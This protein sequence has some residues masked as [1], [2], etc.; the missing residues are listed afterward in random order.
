M[1]QQQ[2]AQQSI[3]GFDFARDTKLVKVEGSLFPWTKKDDTA[4]SKAA[5]A[6]NADAE[7]YTTYVKLIPKED[8]LAPQQIL[9]EARALLGFPNHIKW[10]SDGHSAVRN[11]E[12]D[13]VLQDLNNLRVKFY[14][15]VN[16]LVAKLPALEDQARK[17]AH[18]GGLG[19]AFD[20]IGFPTADQVKSRYSFD[21]KL[22]V[23]PD[24]SDLRCQGVS[25]KA[26]AEIEAAIRR[27]QADKITDLH[28]Q[29]VAALEA[30]LSRVVNN[31]TEFS[32]GKIKRFE[33]TLVTNLADLVEALPRLNINGDRAVDQTIAR[34]R[35]LLDGLNKALV[36][37]TLRDKKEAGGEVRKELA[38]EAKDILSK[39]KA[40][41]V[42]QNIQ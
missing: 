31:L 36:N 16:D 17:P 11:T 18:E 13:A 2:Y 26:K 32:D 3:N 10:D 21:V 37:Q 42:S 38:T 34:S 1:S 15:A 39:L 29:V 40:G 14:T 9:G 8:R 25:S 19:D 6:D 28:K 23:A 41:A 35:T 7:R 20:R 27:E 4:A 24:P 12:I 22:G 30:A 33:D 5:A